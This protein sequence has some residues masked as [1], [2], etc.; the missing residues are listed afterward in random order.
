MGRRFSFAPSDRKMN[1]CTPPFFA[2]TTDED[3]RLRF[4]AP[5]KERGHAFV[6][7]LTQLDYA[8]AMAFIALDESSGRDARRCAPACRCKP[9]ER[10]ICRSCAIRHQRTRPRLAVD[11]NDHRI[12]PCRR[13]DN[14]EGQVLS[15]NTTMLTMCREFGFDISDDPHDPHTYI[16]KLS[17]AAAPK[18][19]D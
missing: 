8:R 7:R 18:Q 12:R 13:S 19:A 1:P 4:F 10:R 2:A 14:L 9:R 15:E 17:L 6:A 3:L 16:V 11:A 5:L